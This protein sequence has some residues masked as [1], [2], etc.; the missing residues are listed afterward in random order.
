MIDKRPL[1]IEFI[2]LAVSLVFFIIL[3]VFNSLAFAG[4]WNV[5]IAARDLVNPI[6]ATSETLAEGARIYTENCTKCHGE[7]GLGNGSAKRVDYSL[8]SILKIPTQPGNQLLGD[9]ELYWKITHGIGEMPSFAGV[10]TDRE[11]W[12]MVNHI[13]ALPDAE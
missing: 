7:D 1:A 2:F 4:N 10:L 13:R 6:A 12:L 5:P 11:R 8:Q 3:S 9:G